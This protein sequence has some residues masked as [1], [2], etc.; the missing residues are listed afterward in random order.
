MDLLDIMDIVVKAID[1]F[2]AQ[3]SPEDKKKIKEALM[4]FF[5]EG[6]PAAETLGI[7]KEDT[8]VVYNYCVGLYEGGKYEEA[9]PG[10][11]KLFTQDPHN[12]RY[13]F[14]FAACLHKLKRYDEAIQNY[15]VMAN[16]D[17]DNPVPWGH[18]ADCYIQL[19]KIELAAAMLGKGI[20]I[21][22]D[23]PEHQKF[24]ADASIVHNALRDQLIQ[25]KATA[26]AAEPTASA[27]KTK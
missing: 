24:K 15:L 21:A 5:G 22:G 27:G 20:K 12:P 16:V 14:G 8:E 7:P 4:Q 3:C 17:P 18:M 9:L 2:G 1:K 6:K 26:L 11:W 25:K 23:R 10:F 19:G 13:S